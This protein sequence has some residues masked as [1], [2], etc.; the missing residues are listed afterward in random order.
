MGLPPNDLKF[1]HAGREH[2]LTGPEGG[3]VVHDLFA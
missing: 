3:Q 2:R 1:W